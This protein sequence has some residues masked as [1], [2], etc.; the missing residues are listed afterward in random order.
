[1]IQNHFKH[2]SNFL[3]KKPNFP[4]NQLLKMDL[5]LN[6]PFLLSHWTCSRGP[7]TSCMS[8]H[9]RAKIG[10]FSMSS[11]FKSVFLEKIWLYKR[12]SISYLPL[13]VGGFELNRSR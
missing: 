13:W 1:M 3:F 8:V 7:L 10:R 4:R 2:S 11:I 9:L 6:L 12:N 5:M